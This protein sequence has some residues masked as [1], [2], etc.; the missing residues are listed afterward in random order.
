MAVLF[1]TLT[2]NVKKQPYIHNI[3]LNLVVLGGLLVGVLAMR[4]EFKSCRG[5]CSF[6]GDKNP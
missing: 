6:R 3:Y 4:R 5:Q 2:V 1:T